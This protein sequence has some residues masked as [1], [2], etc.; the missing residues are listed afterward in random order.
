MPHVDFASMRKRSS[1]APGLAPSRRRVANQVWKAVSPMALGA[2]DAMK[3]S[4]KVAAPRLVNSVGERVKVCG[5]LL[6]RGRPRVVGCAD[7]CGVG[8]AEDE[9]TVRSG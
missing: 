8:V 9:G 7:V 4:A 6:G 3:S 1:H 5:V 2:R